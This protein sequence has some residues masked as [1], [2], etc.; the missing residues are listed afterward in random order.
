MEL[1]LDW[2][3][4]EEAASVMRQMNLILKEG[5]AHYWAG[6]ALYE[7]PLQSLGSVPD[8]GTSSVF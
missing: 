1:G 3:D 8:L 4:G 7:D 5:T 6:T 2:N